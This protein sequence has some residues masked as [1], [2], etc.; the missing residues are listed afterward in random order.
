MTGRFRFGT[1]LAFAGIALH[2]CSAAG[3]SVD[4]AAESAGPVGHWTFADGTGRDS[5]GH[6]AEM[7]LGGGRV[8]FAQQSPRAIDAGVRVGADVPVDFDG[9]PRPAGAAPDAGAYERRP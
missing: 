7:K 8:L 6:G 3:A 4:S 9:R 2:S 5:S 1:V